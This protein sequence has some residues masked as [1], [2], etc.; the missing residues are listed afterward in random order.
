MNKFED[1]LV[2]KGLYDKLAI[3]KDDI[4]DLR[5]LLLQSF[6]Y[7]KFKIDCYCSECNEIRTFEIV[8]K[9]INKRSG[10]FPA[11]G[12]EDMIPKTKGELLQGLLRQRYSISFK[13]TREPSHRVYFDLLLTDSH[14]IKIGQYPSIA[15]ISISEIKKYKQILQS[16]YYEFS[17]AI[18][19]FS[20]GIG[21]GS[22][23]YLRRII[24]N[25]IIQEFDIHK[26]MIAV[27][28]EDFTT[29]EFKNKIKIVED[30]IPSFLVKNTNVYS[31]LSK[32][33][34]ELSEDECLSIFPYMKVAIE[35]ILDEKI[36][37][38]EKANKEKI[39]STY[40]AKTTG[41]L[42]KRS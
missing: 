31:I 13:C 2:T 38:K 15:D 5:C 29:M 18:G 39:I 35:L 12:Y 9:E 33:I 6:E 42:K 28:V 30:Y 26:D 19:L 10:S 25:L 36:S 14:I 34:H 37:K 22:F 11:P 20:H 24:E 40:I 3:N 21:V 8:E 17:K 16:E 41:D 4:D 27:S 32:G 1:L 23:V 7:P